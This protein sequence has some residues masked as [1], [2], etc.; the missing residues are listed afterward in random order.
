MFGK[1]IIS[2]TLTSILF[3][4]LMTGYAYGVAFSDAESHWAKDAIEKWSELKIIEGDGEKFRPDDDI[5]RAEMAV[6]I[7]R[8]MSYTVSVPN[9][10]SDL[11]MSWYT[12]AILKAN[13]AGVMLGDGEKVRPNDKITRQEAVVMLARMFDIAQDEGEVALSY[14]DASK[15]AEWAL[16]YVGA[17]TN[18]KY[19][20]GDN[21]KF[22]PQ[23]NLTRAQTVTM[24]D[25]ILGALYNAPGTYQQN[26]SGNALINTGG[27]TLRDVT[28]EGDLII[29]PGAKE[30]EINLVNVLVMGEMKNNGSASISIT[31][32]SK[33]EEEE[34]VPPDPI[35][36]PDQDTFEYRDRTLQ[37][38]KN[39]EKNTYNKQGFSQEGSLMYYED[40]S[41]SKTFCGVDISSHQGE[42]VDWEKL[43]AAGVDF[44]ILR[45]GYR[46]YT[47]GSMNI[48]TTFKRNVQ[49]A[50][51]AGINVGV[52]FFSQAITAEEAVEEADFVLEIIK[53]YDISYPVVFDWENISSDTARTT[54][55]SSDVVTDCAIAFCERVED[56]GYMPMVYFNMTI[57]YFYYDLGRLEGYDFWFAG[58]TESPNF[59]YHFDIWQ[60]TSSGSI[61]GV[62]GRTD[63]N[64]SFVDYANR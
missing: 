60:Y 29:S 12:D 32:L 23:S 31:N 63:M 55:I 45:V 13:A 53:D 7:N 2:L 51:E 25:N 9:T 28:V 41:I 49:A 30:G 61:D 20:Q 40:S 8:V 24:L 37:V 22:N 3:L 33:S 15:V 47:A 5:T 14:S 26:I 35:I 10:F 43:K 38:Y 39:L 56:A 54:G 57:G 27:V 6:I 21:N 19:I 52:Y 58:Y 44:A 50:T 36:V 17:M 42:N 4:S 48:D 34:K 1:R 16:G 62:N 59:Y 64:I 18:L 46:G 11:D